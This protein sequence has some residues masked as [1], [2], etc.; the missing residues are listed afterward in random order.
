MV[1]IHASQIAVYKT[2]PRMYRFR[3]VDR[4]VPKVESEKLVLGKG[5]HRALQAYY[6]GQDALATYDA[7]AEEQLAR[8]SS[9]AWSDELAKIEDQLS[10]GRKL[11]TYYVEWARRNDGFRVLS[12]EQQFRVPVWSPKGKKVPGVW[13]AGTYD[14]IAEDVYGNLWLLEHKFYNY[15]PSETELRLN[16][17]AGYY[18]LAAVQLFP[19]R[20]VRGVIYTVIRK[21]NP[22]RAK[23]DVVRRWWVQRNEHEIA[24]LRD[25]LY[26]AY[27]AI[28]G[29]K[30]WAPSPGFHCTWQCAYTRL[31]LAE[32]DGSD[33]EELVDVFYTTEE[34]GVAA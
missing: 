9:V 23:D 4:L 11:I 20:A 30:V 31:C 29:D 1:E 24:A 17:Q 14:G 12:A 28:A 2:C 6:S 3:Y 15:F 8:F 18:L 13:H 21:A 10:L 7:W 27:R 26:Y 25:R 19:D 34:E 5:G 33:T 32:D 16:E 22:D